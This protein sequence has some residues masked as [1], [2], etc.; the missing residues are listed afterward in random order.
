MNSFA[1]NF[2]NLAKEINVKYKDVSIYF[3]AFTHSTYAN[4]HKIKCNERLEYIGDA[5]LDFLVG[6]FLYNNYPNLPE[7]ELSKKRAN[8]VNEEANKQYALALG[9]D[10][11]LMLG[12]GEE[13][14]G[15]RSKPS[16]L[17]NLFEAFLGAVYIDNKS[18][19]EVRKILAKVVF[20]KILG[21][22][23]YLIDYKSKLQE[24]I[25]SENRKTVNYVVIKEEGP[26]HDKKYTVGVYF[27]EMKLGEG[28]GKSKKEAE[29]DSAKHALE[30]LARK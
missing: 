2:K 1:T 14:Q 18:V 20:P 9:L 5:I 3:L 13:K 30:K 29:Q 28:V 15:G 22:T 17:G 16:I 8:Y 21:S 26:S 19:N 11:L 6:E 25:Q 23:D 24:L 12:K 7:G 4:E 27:E 10:K